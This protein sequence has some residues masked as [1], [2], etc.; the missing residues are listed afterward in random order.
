MITK[1]EVQDL[2]LNYG[3]FHALKNINLQ[4]EEKARITSYNVCY[5]KLLRYGFAT[6]T[7]AKSCRR[8]AI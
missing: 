1:I 6:T 7:I 2:N 4:V 3:N 5:T 8:Q